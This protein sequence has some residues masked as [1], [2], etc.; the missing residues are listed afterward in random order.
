MVDFKQTNKQTNKQNKFPFSLKPSE[1][2][3]NTSTSHFD[4]HFSLD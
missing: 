3:Q 2:V 1:E 4:L